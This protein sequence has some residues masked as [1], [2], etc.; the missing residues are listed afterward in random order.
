VP[1]HGYQS[2]PWRVGKNRHKQKATRPLPAWYYR[3]VSLGYIKDRDPYPEDFDEDLSELG[4]SDKSDEKECVCDGEDSDCECELGDEDKESERSYDGS[5]A[6][7]YYELKEI[8]KERK[9]EL[10]E[11]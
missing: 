4:S 8:R 7:N 2:Q 11:Q 9:R 6:G 5:D 3:V 1:Y 10:L